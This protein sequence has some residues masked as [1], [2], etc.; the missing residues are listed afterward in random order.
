MGLESSTKT[1]K[2]TTTL[3]YKMFLNMK[4]VSFKVNEYKQIF[5]EKDLKGETIN[6]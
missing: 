5:I 6:K 3:L 4:L 2:M 1:Q